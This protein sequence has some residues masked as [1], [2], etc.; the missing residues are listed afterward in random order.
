M[1]N[2]KTAVVT[3]SS[4]GIGLNIS[5]RLLLN[6][7][8]VYGISRTKP[9]INDSN[10]IWIKA[11]LLKGECF[12]YIGSEVIEPKVDLLVNNAGVVIAEKSLEFTQETFNKTYGLN[13]IAPVKLTS[14]LNTKLQN[15]IV[16]NI[17]STS[18]RFAEDSLALYCSSKA[19]LNMYFDAVGVEN[20]K[21]KVIN[22]L[23]IYVD[24]PMLSGISK[25]LNFSVVDAVNPVKFAETVIKIIFSASKLE[26]GSRVIVVPNKSV[27]DINDP[28]RLWYYDM[29]TDEFI[30]LK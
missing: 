22:I 21:L 30:K 18:D 14:I 5:K 15:G 17:S 11:D 3:G 25:K 7:F 9:P 12:K 13:L 24:T 16:V 23:P 10:F 28:E 29:S 2:L 20:P 6:N 4:Y 27:D 26:S 1:N 8:R 19:A